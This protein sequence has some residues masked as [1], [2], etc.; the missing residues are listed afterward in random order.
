M[1]QR[2]RERLAESRY[3]VAIACHMVIAA[4]RGGQ[5]KRLDPTWIVKSP[6]AV[7]ALMPY[8]LQV[9]EW[10]YTMGSWADAASLLR[11]FLVHAS[12]R[13]DWLRASG[14]TVNPDRHLTHEDLHAVQAYFE[15]GGGLARWPGLSLTSHR[16]VFEHYLPWLVQDADLA[17]QV[18]DVWNA[19]VERGEADKVRCPCEPCLTLYGKLELSDTTTSGFDAAD[20][21]MS[22]PSRASSEAE[23]EL[24]EEQAIA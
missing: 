23:P 7:R 6:F 8:W 12:Q 1:S 2:K 11:P 20:A 14:S 24:Q 18:L 17:Q 22:S 9:E 4:T 21:S 3:N 15:N 13:R 5:L 10:A 19:I 16:P